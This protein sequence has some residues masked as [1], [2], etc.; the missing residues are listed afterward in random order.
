[1]S[2]INLILKGEGERETQYTLPT[3]FYFTLLR[4]IDAPADSLTLTFLNEDIPEIQFITISGDVD[5]YGVVDTITKKSDKSGQKTTLYCR[6]IAAML[7]DTQATPGKSARPNLDVMS[8]IASCGGRLKGFLYNSYTP[9]PYLNT[10]AGASM[11]NQITTFCQ[12]T[13]GYP[14]RITK[15]RYIA[16]TPYSSEVTHTFSDIISVEDT[17]DFSEPILSV[18]VRNPEGAYSL[19]MSNPYVTLNLSR[20]R[21]VTPGVGWQ[22][23]PELYGERIMKNSM[24][25]YKTKTLTLSGFYPA[26]I[27]D[28]AV[29]EGKESAVIGLNYTF[30][31]N[32]ATTKVVLCDK[33]Y[34]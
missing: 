26:E 6:S 2:N 17:T 20:H 3:P 1:M 19:T 31:Q 8:I 30:N 34:L 9:I 15:D 5:F 32:G 33:K 29:F 28:N 23:V 11:W 24:V 27:G 12:Q 14:P 4:D 16:A 7:L 22:S 21:F 13:M 25:R 10:S 18:S